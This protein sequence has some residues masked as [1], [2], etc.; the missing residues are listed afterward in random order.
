MYVCVCQV[1]HFNLLPL[2]VTVIA[3]SHANTGLVMSLD[4]DI[5]PVVSQLAQV[6][7]I[8]SMS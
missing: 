4:K 8:A 1:V 6:V 5:A 3:S 2:V 7:D